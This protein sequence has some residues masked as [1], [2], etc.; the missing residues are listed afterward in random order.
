MPGI[1]LGICLF[2]RGRQRLAEEKVYIPPIAKNAMDGAHPFDC[3]GLKKTGNGEN[4][5]ARED[6]FSITVPIAGNLE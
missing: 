3:G 5:A 6:S 2:M 1:L 4:N